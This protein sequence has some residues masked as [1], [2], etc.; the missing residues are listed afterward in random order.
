VHRYRVDLESPS[1]L[2]QFPLEGKYFDTFI[3]IGVKLESGLLPVQTSWR[4]PSTDRSLDSLVTSALRCED[5]LFHLE[6]EIY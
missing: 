3:G 2:S 6:D 4:G 5:P 1:E